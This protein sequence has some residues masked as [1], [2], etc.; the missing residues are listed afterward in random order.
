MPELAEVDYYRSQWN[1]GLGSKVL[2]VQLN[3]EKRVFRGN[4]LT[5]FKK[6]VGRK[7]VSSESAGKQMLFRF[8]G[9]LWLGLHLGMTGKISVAAPSHVPEKHDHLVLFQKDRALIFNDARQFGRVLI[10][11]GKEA[12]T[13]WSAIGTA[14]TSPKFTSAYMREFLVRHGRLPVK[15]ALLHQ[16]GFPGIGN[17]MADEILWRAGISPHRASG[18]L[19]PAELARLYTEV[20]F[21]AREAMKKIS[22]DFGDVPN[23]WLFHQRWSAKGICPKH[24]VPLTRETIGGR[25]TAWCKKCQK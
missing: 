20:R 12:P 22:K 17:W 24:K 25:T 9:H 16:R 23:N 5:L 21:V 19:K 3:A 13:W 4:D 10:H 14:V 18:T 11:H 7:L 8:S 2:R 6:L 15:A 1:P